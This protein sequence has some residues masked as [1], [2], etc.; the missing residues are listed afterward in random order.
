MEERG[1]IW[2]SS[3]HG[4]IPSM[5][6]SEKGSPAVKLSARPTFG[7]SKGWGVSGAMHVTTHERPSAPSFLDS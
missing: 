6:I 2:G 4:Q 1:R 7:S 5:P 3:A